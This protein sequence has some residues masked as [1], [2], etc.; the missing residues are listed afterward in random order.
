LDIEDPKLSLEE[1]AQ[2][3]TSLIEA[4]KLSQT[5]SQIV[6]GTKTLHH[7]IP[8]LVPPMDRGYTRRFFGFWGQQFQY[9]PDIFL[10]IWMRFV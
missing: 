9:H 10:Y 8:D 1:T 4:M 7:I 2:Q 5:G 3:L 6:T